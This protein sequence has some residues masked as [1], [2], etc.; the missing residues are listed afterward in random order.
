MITVSTYIDVFPWDL[1]TMILGLSN[2]CDLNRHGVKGH[3]GVNDLWFKFLEKMSVY[4]HTL[5]YFKSNITMISKVCDRESRR[6]SWFE[7]R[8]VDHPKRARCHY[9][10]KPTRSQYFVAY[11]IDCIG[12]ESL[13]FSVCSIICEEAHFSRTLDVNCRFDTGR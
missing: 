3:L 12:S 11:D 7:N 10:C 2:T 8:L 4:P 13:C 5:M 6:D 9:G 1:D